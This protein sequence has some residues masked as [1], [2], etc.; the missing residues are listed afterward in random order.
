VQLIMINGN[1]KPRLLQAWRCQMNCRRCNLGNTTRPPN[2]K[3]SSKLTSKSSGRMPRRGELSPEFIA[4]YFATLA[5]A[6]PTELRGPLEAIAGK[7][8]PKMQ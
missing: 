3:A 7:Y 8:R 5:E 6:L 1:G 4:D 2:C